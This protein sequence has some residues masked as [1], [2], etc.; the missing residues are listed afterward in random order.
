MWSPQLYLENGKKAGLAPQ[1]LQSA[2]KQIQRARSNK[3]P[4]PPILSLGHLAKHTDLE[5][6][7]LRRYA[8][9]G[10]TDPYL[11]FTIAKRSGGVRHIA[12]PEPKLKQVQ[13]WIAKEVLSKVAVHPASHA[14]GLGDSTVKCASVHCGASW[15][16]KIDIADFF[17]SVTEIQ[18]WRA[19][20][21]LGYNPLVSLELARICTDRIPHSAKY[22]LP[23]WKVHGS[24]YSI[25]AYQAQVLGRLP[26]GA[27]TSPMLSNLTMR[28]VDQEIAVIAS[29][30]K[31][32]Y[33]RYSDDM[34]F[35]TT[36]EFSRADGHKLIQEIAK[37]LMKRGLFLNRKKSAVIPPGA[38][39]VVL[40]LLV[41]R[42]VP[43]LPR[44]FKDRLKQHLYHLQKHGIEAH[45]T[46]RE[47]D[48][49]GGMYRHL[50]GTINYANMVDSV[51][52]AK[53]RS[54]FESLPWPG[55]HSALRMANDQ[56]K[57]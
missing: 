12:V 24:P 36:G 2:L 16:V 11:R 1:V 37:T 50:Q 43:T 18:A 40:G 25:T 28:E 51:F 23:A 13:A 57:G 54:L 20:R 42:Q 48:S 46:R 29:K 53:M 47:F 34:N 10:G 19:F 6:K 55:K 49:V 21:S 14:F 31:V 44:D 4:V 52:A 45:A 41:D 30:F 7:T 38:R 27:P 22:E 35:S 39:K 8:S 9:R 17:G 33:T 56:H 32:R 5:Y 15:L 26:Q 3:P